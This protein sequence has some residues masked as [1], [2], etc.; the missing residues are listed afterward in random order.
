[1]HLCDLG[2]FGERLAVAG[3]AGSVSLDHY[4]IGKDY[5]ERVLSLANRNGLRLLVSPE[6][7]EREPA[8]HFHSV[9]VLCGNGPA[10]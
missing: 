10:A 9:L 4:R 5:S 7:R 3:D 6:L 1:V 8:R 2:A